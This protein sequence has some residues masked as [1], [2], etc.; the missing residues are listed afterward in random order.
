MGQQKLLQYYFYQYYIVTL[1][2]QRNTAANQN[3]A[4]LLSKEKK[5]FAISQIISVLY[6]H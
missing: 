1:K 4:F 6:L 3:V 5:S 2:F